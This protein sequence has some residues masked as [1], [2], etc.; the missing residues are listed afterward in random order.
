MVNWYR[1]VWHGVI[2]TYVV[3]WYGDKVHYYIYNMNWY[4]ML[5]AF[6]T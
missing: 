6:F 2:W 4:G 5:P 3:I 1:M